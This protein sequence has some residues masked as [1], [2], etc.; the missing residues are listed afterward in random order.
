MSL[1]SK[2]RELLGFAEPVAA[3]EKPIAPEAP[4][5]ER[6]FQR[7]LYQQIK[8]LFTDL[9]IEPSNEQLL[10]SNGELALESSVFERTEH[11]RAV[12]E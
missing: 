8:L 2:A 1:L 12:S 6:E 9:A 4:A 3:I 5:I 10:F 7:Q 11:P